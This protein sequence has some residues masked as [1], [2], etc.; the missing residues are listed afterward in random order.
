MPVPRTCPRCWD[1]GAKHWGVREI[2]RAPRWRGRRARRRDRRVRRQARPR[3]A[4]NTR[5]VGS[6]R[7]PAECFRDECPA[8]QEAGTIERCL[9]ALDEVDYPSWDV[10]VVAGG[11]DGT[12]E[13]A[14]A[15]V[16]DLDRVTVIRQGPRGKNAALN[17]GMAHATGENHRLPRRR[18]TPS[19]RLA[20][21]PRDTTRRQDPRRDRAGDPD[22]ANG[23]RTCRG[24]RAHFHVRS[25]W[26]CGP[27]GVRQHRDPSRCA[28]RDL[29]VS[30]RTCA[31]GVDWDLDRRL[32]RAGI[33]RA[34]ARDAVVHTERPATLR[35]FWQNELRWRRAHLASTSC[36]VKLTS[37]RTAASCSRPL[38]LWVGLARPSPP[39]PLED[40][41]SPWERVTFGSA[42]SAC[43]PLVAWLAVRRSAIVIQVAAY[44]GS[45]R[46]LTLLAGRT[47]LSLRD[48][49]GDCVA[50]VT[51]HRR[52]M[53]FKGP[54]PV[55][56][57]TT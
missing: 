33:H 14:R 15:A 38:H 50:T 10:L 24:P 44:T 17:A 36:A 7:Q 35:E 2:R 6:P 46:W 31:V 28:R 53:H 40:W 20:P 29:V 18:F 16:P 49:R 26:R 19:I 32:A 43:G 9:R 3:R 45:V 54:R 5:G 41:R 11:A 8:W 48:V 55:D 22:P 21:R 13:A 51:P 42:R 12:L 30:Q 56:E 37:P 34:Y 27:P 57:S 1:T 23:G 4:A 25:A 39:P 52:T 47:G